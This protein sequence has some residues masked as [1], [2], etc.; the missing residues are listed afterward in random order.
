[1]KKIFI[2]PVLFLL[3]TF[4]SCDSE[5][6]IAPENVLIEDK[7][8]EEAGSAELA[9]AGLY[10][11]L[12]EAN[13]SNW[14]L[15]YSIG[16]IT[17]DIMDLPASNSNMIYVTGNIPLDN[18]LSKQ[19]WVNFYSVINVANVFIARVPN[20]A[21]YDESTKEK[22][23]GEAKFIRAY[24]YLRL[25]QLFGN[26]ALTGNM[27]GMCV[28]L[29]LDPYDGLNID[30]Y[31]PRNT[32]GKV[33]AQIISDLNDAVE[34]L[35]IEH[36]SYQFSVARATKDAA[37]AL[38]ARIY[39]YKKEYSKVIS[40][41]DKVIDAGNHE[42]TDL[43]LVYRE[44]GDSQFGAFT[45][46]HIWSL[47]LFGNGGNW[48]FGSNE[49]MSYENLSINTEFMKEYSDG[50]SRKDYLIYKVEGK[51]FYRTKKYSEPDKH[52]N[53]TILRYSEVLLNKAEALA[54]SGVNKKSVDLINDVRER[55][56]LSGED[57]YMIEDFTSKEQLLKAIWQERKLEFACEGMERYDLIRTNRSLLDPNIPS[58]RLVLPIPQSEVIITEGVLK[59]NVGYL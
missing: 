40:M 31:I 38:L 59:Q 49:L 24:S 55:A 12:I 17:T 25:L 53:V 56:G 50:D 15:A 7:V 13:G 16:D 52:D 22:H 48:Q 4:Q 42:L 32:N 54:I 9:M 39:L 10:H 27:D 37:Y 30:N 35:P 21:K 58:N 11:K 44:V 18:E 43:G 51:E 20:I 1:M 19:A 29:Q 41:T 14:G 6:D 5:L 33:Y 8:F 3:M 57:L 26:G 47:E 28:P 34:L 23:I 46:E 36:E 2:I 45:K